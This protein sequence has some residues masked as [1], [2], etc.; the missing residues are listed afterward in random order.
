MIKF[1]FPKFDWGTKEVV[2]TEEPVVEVSLPEETA[3]ERFDALVKESTKARLECEL[4]EATATALFKQLVENNGYTLKV[5]SDYTLTAGTT[6]ESNRPAWFFEDKLQDM[7]KKG[8]VSCSLRAG[9]G[10]EYRYHKPTT[11][12]ILHAFYLEA[13]DTHL[14]TLME[15]YNA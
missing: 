8:L 2:K 13:L 1:N 11:E 6:K 10:Y 15:D 5:V 3:K 9:Y 4:K 12:Q 14:D 7:C